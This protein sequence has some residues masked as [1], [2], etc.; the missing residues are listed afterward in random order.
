[1]KQSLDILVVDDDQDL[2]LLMETMLKFSGHN[3]KRCCIPSQLPDVLNNFHP[4][5]MVM[6]MLLSGK[7]GRDICRELKQNEDTKDIK[8]MMVS[9]HHDAEKACKEAGADDFLGKPFDMDA[10][11]SKAAALLCS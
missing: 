10:F 7:D 5:A 1:M 3:V 9:A 6:D 8:I 11:T 4:K 2:C